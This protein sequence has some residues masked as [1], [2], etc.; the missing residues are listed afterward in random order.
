LSIG[1]N[2]YRSGVD[3]GIADD[4]SDEETPLKTRKTTMDELLKD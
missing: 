2:V 1:F 3:D 4:S